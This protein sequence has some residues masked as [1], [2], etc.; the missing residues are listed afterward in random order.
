MT[1]MKKRLF[2]TVL[3][4]LVSAFALYAEGG[5]GGT[6]AALVTYSDAAQKFSI[7]YPGPWTRDPAFNGVVKFAGG[8]DSMTLEFVTPDAGMTLK[9]YAEKDAAAL[10]SSIP[11]FK[12]L[13]IAPSREVKAALILGYK[14]SGTSTITGKTYTAHAERYYIP[15]PDGRIAVLTMTGPERNY[16]REGFRDIALTLKVKK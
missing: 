5:E 14:S 7:G 12:S 3:A 6:E 8:D 2:L 10:S 15:L 13:G 1:K 11:A 9:A 4:A 16:D